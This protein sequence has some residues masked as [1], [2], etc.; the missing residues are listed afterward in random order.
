[1]IVTLAGHV[2]HGKTS[3]VKALSGIDTDRLLE[4]KRRGLTI[5][6]GF[7]YINEQN[8]DIGFV[9]VPGHH[10][11]IHN[12]LAGVTSTQFA[13]L[14]VAADDGP[15][16]QTVEHLNILK[17][18]GLQQ[19][20]VV[21]TKIDK[22]SSQEVESCL[23]KIRDLLIGSFLETCQISCVS[24][25]TKVGITE[26][27]QVLVSQAKNLEK[28]TSDNCFRLAVDRV[29]TIKGSGLVVT[30]AIHSGKI[31]MYTPLLASSN[32]T[33]LRVRKLYKQNQSVQEAQTGDRCSLNLT[34]I[35]KSQISRGD[36]ILEP[37][38]YAESHTMVIDLRV[39]PDFPRTIKHWL[40]VH[41]YHATSHSTGKIALLDSAPLQPGQT[42]R[43]E[44]VLDAPLFPKRKDRV[45]LREF[46]AELTLGGGEVID[47]GQ[48]PYRRRDLRRLKNLENLAMSDPEA[49]LTAMLNPDQDPGGV[50]S[51][52]DLPLFASNWN[53]S[54]AQ[55]DKL[56]DKLKAKT[57]V[58]DSKRYAYAALRESRAETH[59]IELLTQHHTDNPQSSGIKQSS[60]RA[61]IDAPS[62]LTDHIIAQ[63]ETQGNLKIEAG[64]V[65][66]PSH[67]QN[68]PPKV[69]ALFQAYV[70]VAK[71]RDQPPSLGD[72]AKHINVA[73]AD[74]A[75][76][77][78]QAARTGM[79]SE[80]S[81]N[82]FFLPDQLQNMIQH[83][84]D[85]T[86]NEATFTV[87][88]YRD[89]TGIGRNTAIEV[90]EYFD[91]KGFTKRAGNL[92][93]R[94]G[95]YS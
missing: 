46:G 28:A 30:G 68:L 84:M 40:P 5:D 9:D 7:A 85:L 93:K 75:R 1:M 41:I 11:F 90:L 86:T 20:M 73:Q 94:I 13:L 6:L 87:K 27:L 79:V 54:S 83:V 26:L 21:V 17:I 95:E 42:A 19:G 23:H 69:K 77:L 8:Q 2:D 78:K 36:W 64:L 52:V 4:E 45:V 92:R 53:L 49:A 91:A 14:V 24:T 61:L 47:I 88:Q 76:A 44:L 66:L 25:Y 3:L 32:A 37:A 50:F 67:N 56:A 38:A 16:P 72:A 35:D 51:L 22:V 34:G 63:L 33:T 82:R 71:N 39:L 48:S 31:D 89:K 18:M 15:M 60:I 55:L 10:K 70:T 57:L 43:V 74:L 59:I 58:Q 12:M 29:F 81:A 80:I 62:L 65:H